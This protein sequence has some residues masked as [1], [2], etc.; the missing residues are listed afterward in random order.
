MYAESLAYRMLIV[1][2]RMLA[3]MTRLVVQPPFS[4]VF[5]VV[6]VDISADMRLFLVTEQSSCG[7]RGFRLVRFSMTRGM[8]AERFVKEKLPHLI[9]TCSAFVFAELRPKRCYIVLEKS[10][11]RAIFCHLLHLY[12]YRINR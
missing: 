5:S 1:S 11:K 7:T 4:V 9:S 2:N 6:F 10:E 12:S 8:A 3:S